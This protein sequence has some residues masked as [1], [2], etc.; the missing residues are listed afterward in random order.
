[1]GKKNTDKVST[2]SVRMPKE[3]WALCK[4]LSSEEDRSLSQQIMHYVKIGMRQE[5]A[6]AEDT[7]PERDADEPTA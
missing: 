6:G 5:Q 4:K 2:V 3:L 1:M 7:C